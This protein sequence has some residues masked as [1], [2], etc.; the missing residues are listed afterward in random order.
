MTILHK[1]PIITVRLRNPR[2]PLMHG[3]GLMPLDQL[4]IFCG[5]AAT[6]PVISYGLDII[7]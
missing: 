3:G 4:A 1:L 5:S 6:P 2:S 7:I